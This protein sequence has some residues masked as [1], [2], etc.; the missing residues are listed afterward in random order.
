MSRASK[1]KR[2]SR[3]SKWSVGLASAGAHNVRLLDDCDPDDP[4]WDAMGSCTLKKG[5]VTADE[6][7]DET[8]SHDLSTA[9]IGYLARSKA[10]ARA[11][12]ASS[13]SRCFQITNKHERPSGG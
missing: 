3:L 4:A 1:V 7:L 11:I 12:I 6:F 9:V 13:A 5:D 2:F 10:S 8:D